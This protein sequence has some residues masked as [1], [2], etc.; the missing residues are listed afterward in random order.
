MVGYDVRIVGGG[1]AGLDA[2]LQLGR[3]L[4]NVLICD[5]NG[6]RNSP[7]DEVHGF[8]TWEGIPPQELH[9]LGREEVKNYNVKFQ[10]SQV[11][12]VFGDKNGFTS[13]LS[14]DETVTRRKVV[15]ATGSRDILPDRDGYEE[16][17]GNEVYHCPYCHGYEVRRESLGVL[18]GDS[19]ALKYT[20]LIVGVRVAERC[21]ANTEIDVSPAESTTQT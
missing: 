8:L 2:A 16:L 18:V 19:H 12:S 4:R 6:Q 14:S 7:A 10:D 3:S 21:N 1:P 13:K 9:Q 15:L 11:T 17:W 5:N 20:K